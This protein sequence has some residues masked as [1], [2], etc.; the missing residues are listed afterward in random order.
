[1]NQPHFKNYDPG[2]PHSIDYPDMTMVDVLE[3]NSQMIPSNPALYFYGNTFTYQYFWDLANNFASA[4]QRIFI[5]KGDRV[6]ILLPNSPQFAF[7]FYG[8]LRLGAV[9]VPIVP[10]LSEKECTDIIK[11]SGAKAIVGLDILLPKISR[12]RLHDRL[13]NAFV[14]GITDYMPSI[15]SLV[16]NLKNWDQPRSD[17]KPCGSFCFY[18]PFIKAVGASVD[19]QSAGKIE[20]PKPDDLAAL[21]YTSGTT[22]DPKG[23]MLSHRNL[24]VNAFQCR[25]WMPRVVFGAEVFDGDLPFCHSFGMTVIMNLC[26]LLGGLNVLHPKFSPK[27]TLN[28]IKRR[29]ITIMAGAPI[30]YKLLLQRERKLRRLKK[31]N[32][33]KACILGAGTM[34][35][36][37]RVKFWNLTGTRITE[38]WG[39]SEASPVLSVN[40]LQGAHKIG[41]VGVPYPDTEVEVA[42]DGELRARGPQIM[43]G[44][45][46]K[47]KETAETIRDGWLY[48]GD[49]GK[50]DEDGFIYITGRK[51][52]MTKVGGENVWF[53]E[54]ENV[55]NQ[56]PKVEECQAV[57][58][59]DE[60]LENHI[61]VIIVLKDGNEIFLPEVIEF[62][63]GKLARF[64]I[65][66]ELEIVDAL[67]KT[68]LGKIVRR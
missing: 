51:K 63:K 61:K 14:T 27:Q 32:S 45:W 37:D 28:A 43:Q 35:E 68:F 2:V 56:H 34:P 54:V 19:G 31:L 59:P 53:E 7:A 41:S 67:Q 18:Q 23:S 49:M 13:D 1:M 58:V 50:I 8:I 20:K 44:Y 65:P 21:I 60:I 48:T 29:K 9:A 46:K 30:M 42:D 26:V 5:K 11:D 36:A 33:L 39:L 38:G 25:Y 47:D 40:P 64:K 52:A 10:L 24:L 57:A 66:K 22:G 17:S 55:I 6:A 62:C 4:L 3:H 15:P 16:Y 12:H